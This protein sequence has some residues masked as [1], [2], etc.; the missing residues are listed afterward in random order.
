MSRL[1]RIAV[2]VA[3]AFVSA[4]AYADR[5]AEQA[6]AFMNIYAVCL[7]HL[8][9]FEKLRAKLAPLPK[10]PPEKAA[11]FLLDRPG[12][13]WPVPD[14]S[15]YFV[16]SL[17]RNRNE[18][19][20]HAREADTAMVKAHFRLLTALAPPPFKSA[21]ISKEGKRGV[22]GTGETVFYEWHTESAGRSALLGLTTDPSPNA[23]RQAFATVGWM[24][25]EPQGKEKDG[26]D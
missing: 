22:G 17:L 12:D 21:E 2:A 14:K 24:R 20:V 18:C 9:D 7:R 26:G 15:G 23:G 3:L 19:A 25:K 8:D 16:L 5:G 11:I 4:A 10:L 6:K 1:L 13:A